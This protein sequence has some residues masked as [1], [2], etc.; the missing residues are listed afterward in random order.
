MEKVQKKKNAVN[1]KSRALL[2]L[3]VD[4]GPPGPPKI[5]RIRDS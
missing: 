1:L 3:S 4:E 5:V 2:T